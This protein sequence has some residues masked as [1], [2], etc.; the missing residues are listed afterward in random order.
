MNCWNCRRC[1][2]PASITAASG[3]QL[4]ERAQKRFGAY[5]VE[6]IT[7]TLAIKEQ[8]AYPLRAAFEDRTARSRMILKSSRPIALYEK[9]PPVQR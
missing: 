8:L 3:R 4:V 7:F 5:K 1:A 9:K 6:P 2:G